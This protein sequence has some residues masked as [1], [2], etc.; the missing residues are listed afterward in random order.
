VDKEPLEQVLKYLNKELTDIKRKMGKHMALYE[1]DMLEVEILKERLEEL[2]EQEQ[3]LK[4]RKGEIENQ[5][6]TSNA[7][8][9]PLREFCNVFKRFDHEKRKQL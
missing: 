2:K 3:R 8:P 5:L 9:I 7:A 4:V 1:N 6:H